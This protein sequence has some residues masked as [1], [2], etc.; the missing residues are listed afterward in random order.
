MVTH[1]FT[2]LLYAFY[3]RLGTPG[4]KQHRNIKLVENHAAKLL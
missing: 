1:S 2:Y 4:Q 3:N